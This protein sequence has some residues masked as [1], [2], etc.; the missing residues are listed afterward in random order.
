MD[1]S[2]QTV[3]YGASI[4]RQTA[5]GRVGFELAWEGN[6]N[7]RPVEQQTGEV[8]FVTV[9]FASGRGVGSVT[10][11]RVG[12]GARRNEQQRQENVLYR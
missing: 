8:L 4:L 2:G 3:N 11:R 7:R 12:D 1:N 6:R 5:S 10:G 9:E